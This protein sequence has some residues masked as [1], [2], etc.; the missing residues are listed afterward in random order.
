MGKAKTQIVLDTNVIIHFIK[1]GC[2]GILHKIY[3]SYDLVI[4]GSVMEEEL[5]PHMS[6]R[7]VLDK[8]MAL[9]KGG[10]RVVD[11]TP[12]EEYEI[13]DFA[14]LEK[15]FGTGESL[16]L[17]YCKYNHNVIASSNV[18]HIYSF[19]EKNDIQ[20]VT[21]TDLLYHAYQIGKMTIEQCD[22]FILAVNNNGSNLGIN[23]MSDYKPRTIHV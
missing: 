18:R 5:P 15:K 10:I 13:A 19:C 12:S 22:E 4:L 23:K 9:I 3:S 20:Y 21:T 6:H 7:K 14:E 1:G 11:W 16:C 2:I 17:V 8:C